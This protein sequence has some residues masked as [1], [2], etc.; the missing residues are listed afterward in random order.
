VR[1]GAGNGARTRDIQLGKLTLYQL[2]YARPRGL[3]LAPNAAPGKDS[4]RQIPAFLQ[5]LACGLLPFRAM[6]TQRH[7]SSRGFSIVE[8][9]IVC[10]VIG[11]IAAIAIPNLVNAIQRGRQA[12][13]VADLRSLS[14]AV[15]MYQQDYA[16]FPVVSDFEDITVINDILVAYMGGHNRNDAWQRPFRYKSDGDNYTLL[17]YGLNGAMDQPWTRGPIHYFDDDLVVEGGAF[18]QWP[19]GVQH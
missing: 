10:A 19:E 8:L 1:I 17:S 2:S 12:R 5:M 7:S 9:L 15:G 4:T 18:L 11:L 3:T 6:N 13:T 14:T 16:K